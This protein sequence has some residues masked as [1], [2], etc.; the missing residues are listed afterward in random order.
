MTEIA[1][2]LALNQCIKEINLS[3]NP[4][5]T[6]EDFRHLLIGLSQNLSVTNLIYDIEPSLVPPERMNRFKQSSRNKEEAGE[7]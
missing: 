3:G 6:L 1:R 4:I 5:G 7:G 2:L